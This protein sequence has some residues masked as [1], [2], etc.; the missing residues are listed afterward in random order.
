MLECLYN[1]GLNRKCGAFDVMDLPISKGSFETCHPTCLGDCN[2]I[3]YTG[4]QAIDPLKRLWY[5]S[6]DLPLFYHTVS[7]D[8]WRG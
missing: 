3:P 5:L 4:R 1:P 8:S 2:C 7:Q 6:E